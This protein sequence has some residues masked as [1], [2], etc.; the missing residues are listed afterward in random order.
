MMHAKAWAFEG[1]F[2]STVALLLTYYVLEP[3]ALPLRYGGL[4][5]W[6]ATIVILILVIQSFWKSQSYL[7]SFPKRGDGTIA[8]YEF[9]VNRWGG[10][11][12]GLSIVVI[13]LAAVHGALFFPSLIGLSLAIW[14]GAVSF[15]ILLIVNLSGV[16]TESKR[17]SRDF[18]PFKRLHILLMLAALVLAILHVESLV[19]AQLLRSIIT[20]T[21]VALV[22]AFVVFLTVPL[23]VRS[24]P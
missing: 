19:G 11:H 8:R 9:A 12:I 20:G 4:L 2:A 21:I 3:N 6:S 18:G 22:G 1:V 24:P 7:R 17:R 15:L 16:F 14:L 13:V 10:V 5:G 23:T